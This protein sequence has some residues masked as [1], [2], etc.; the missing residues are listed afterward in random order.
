MAK[1]TAPLLSFSAGGAIA[2]TQVYSRWRG[3]PYAR[4]YVIPAN[5]RST[6]QV[7]TRDVFSNLN[8]MWKL[9][10]TGLQ[11]PWDLFATGQPF[12]GRNAWLSKNVKLLRSQADM[13]D[14]MFSP[15]AKGGTP[16][17]SITVTAGSSELTVAFTDPTTPTGWTLTAHWAAA[18]IDQAPDLLFVGTLHVA[19]ENSTPPDDV[20]LTGLTPTE[21]YDVG[22]WIEWTKPDGTTAYSVSVGAQGTPTA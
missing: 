19:E 15:G 7:L 12:T 13:S 18:F 11:A 2:K 16:P 21:L 17:D 14:F 4:R 20:V 9:A 3:V 5:P 8:A 1:T 10:P 22:A 6:G